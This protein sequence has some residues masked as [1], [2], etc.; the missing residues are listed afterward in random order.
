MVALVR[1][2][3]EVLTSG[4]AS[5]I[6]GVFSVT[7]SMTKAF[8]VR[9]GIFTNIFMSCKRPEGNVSNLQQRQTL[10]MLWYIKCDSNM[11]LQ[12]NTVSRLLQRNKGCNV[13][14]TKILPTT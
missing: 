10:G 9:I 8:H 12:H 6:I 3:F 5:G 1:L 7:I 4:V 14:L 2:E 11:L 13:Y